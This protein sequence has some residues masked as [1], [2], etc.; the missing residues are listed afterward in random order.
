LKALT[1]IQ[2]WASLVAVGA[3]CIETRSWPTNY[4]GLVAIHAG[5]SWDEMPMLYFLHDS[6]PELD[7]DIKAMVAAL[8]SAGYVYP[9]DMLPRGAIVAVAEIVDC[10]RVTAENT[11]PAPELYFG[12]YSDEFSK[13]GRYAWHLANVRRLPE[14]IPC[15]GAQQL[16]TVPEDVAMMVNN[17]L[18]IQR[19]G[20]VLDAFTRTFLGSRG[21]GDR[22]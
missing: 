19:A 9:W 15:R 17:M 13:R 18:E 8:S 22:T 12:D 5:K 4:R 1:L 10:Q 2:P 3:K 7:P 16:W 21:G 14:P 6:A 20:A 11:P